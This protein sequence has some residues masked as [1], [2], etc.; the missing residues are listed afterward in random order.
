M[1]SA[2]QGHGAMPA[3]GGMANLTDAEMRAAVTYMFQQSVSGKAG[4]PK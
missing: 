3:R 4:A 2:I 1:R